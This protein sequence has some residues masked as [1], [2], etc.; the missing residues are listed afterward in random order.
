MDWRAAAE[1]AET[2]SMYDVPGS[3]ILLDVWLF[4][5]AF[6]LLVGAS[7]NIVLAELR[8]PRPV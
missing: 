5:V 4:A 3:M 7:G 1:V 2:V 8:Q 6:V